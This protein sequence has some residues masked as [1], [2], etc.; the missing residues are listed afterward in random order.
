MRARLAARPTVTAAAIFAVLAVLFV[1][2]GLL[3]GR[4]LS[5]SDA[6]W[7]TAPWVAQKPSSLTRPSNIEF[8]DAPAVLQPF[9]RYTIA[10]LPHIPLWN[11]HIMTGR[12]F[13]AN[14]QA[15]I[16][17]PFNLPA[18]ILPFFTALGWIAALKLWV[19]GFGMY[20][21]GRRLGMRFGGAMV[22]GVVYGFNLW[23]VTWLSYPHSSVWA[24][25]PWMMVAAERAI[26]RPDVRGAAPLAVVVALQ[27]LCGHPESSF[28]AVVATTI[29][30]AI[31]MVALRP[32]WRRP[33]AAFAGAM[34]L[35]TALAALTLVPFAELLLRSADIHQRAGSAQLVQSQPGLLLE[36]FLPDW[37]G[38]PTQYPISLFLL[39]RA[40]YGS[41]LA[42]ML[43]AVA[44]VLRPSRG[45]LTIAALGIACM[46]V[47]LALG[48]VFQIVT[49]LP[50]FSSGHNGRL[51]ILALLC[52]AL[53]AGFGLDDL[54]ARVGS[55]RRRAVALGSAAA[56]FA[57]PLAY[58]V[59]RGRVSWG[60]VGHGL[61]VAWG[62]ASYNLH[63]AAL[64]GVVRDSALWIWLAVAGAGLA[65]VAAG[66]LARRRVEA[67]AL[68]LLAVAVIYGD[69]ARAGMGYNPAI[70][71][72][73]ATQP[74]TPAIDLLRS[75]GPARVVAVGAIP[76][77]AL[78]M[79]YGLY[80]PR[81]YDLPVEQRFDHLWRSTMS[82][83]IRSQVG[84]YPQDIP[85]SLP[86]VTPDRL[87]VLGVMGTRYV[88]QAP[89]DPLLAIPGLTLVHSGP[90]ARVYRNAD[91]QPRAA[92]VGAQAIAPDG[93]AALRDVVAPG[94]R[95]D[96]VAVTEHAIGGLATTT[97]AATPAP[98][99][100]ARISDVQDDSLTVRATARRPGLL[101]VSD[102]W[103]PGW[104]ATVDG[105]PATVHRVDYVFRGVQVGAGSHRVVFTFQPLSWR[106]GWIISLVALLG[107]LAALGISWRRATG[108]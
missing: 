65:I 38:R 87:H 82:P 52:L 11:P 28:H 13:E 17:S 72:S 8:E 35:G 88:I 34:T 75:A 89:S 9:V 104:K 93:A 42:L 92:V 74:A 86:T 53:L 69:L 54:L 81:G 94:F 83:Q 96:R 101:V 3:P 106:V 62:F 78:P 90:D 58:A 50:I 6:F 97:S 37:F 56:I 41:A 2:Q 18:Y 36:S 79:N 44:L 1:G 105:H 29:F 45:R 95:I 73:V 10:S 48:P 32:S 107:L 64:P 84:P 91:V 7:F 59:V 23:E 60:S 47:V 76:Q 55:M 26:R 15:A 99:G 100:T 98:A 71:R 77:D 19:A 14:A 66:T 4:T 31:R 33:L 46:M 63:W 102:A 51:A 39:A 20:L 103:Y 68:A 61:D 22:A 16:F 67:G 5:N 21:L 108:T 49:H 43:G 40:W 24:L 70:K 27:F 12:P 30:F 25:I 85:L 80:E 57:L